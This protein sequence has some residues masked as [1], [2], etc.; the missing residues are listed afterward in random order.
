M[1]RSFVRAPCTHGLKGSVCGRALARCKVWQLACFARNV[2]AAALHGEPR[3]TMASDRRSLIGTC[4][5]KVRVRRYVEKIVG[6]SHAVLALAV[7][8]DP[9]GLR[10]EHTRDGFAIA[11]SQAM[12]MALFRHHASPHA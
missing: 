6:S 5:D 1:M 7:H 3:Y 12:G 8:E 10:Y 4:A 9:N 11:V 2:L